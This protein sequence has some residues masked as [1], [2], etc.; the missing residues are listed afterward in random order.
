MS[1]KDFIP[2]LS[3]A[4]LDELLEYTPAFDRE[5]LANI[6]A[7]TFEKINQKEQPTMKKSSMRRSF[8]AL[9][10][11]CLIILLTSVTVFAAINLL[12]PSEI[13]YEMGDQRLSIA[14]DSDDAIHINKSY[15]TE[16]YRFTLL[17]IVS[18]HA[19]TDI[20]N[21]ARRYLDR[22]YLVVAIEREDGSPMVD[23]LDDAPRFYISPYIRG[24]KPWLVNLHTI[25][26]EGS[27]QH[28]MIIDGIRYV[29]VDME[30][31][32]AFADHGIYIGINTGWVF[33]GDA[34]DFTPDPWE[35]SA[36]PDFEGVSIVFELPICQSFADPVRAAEIL[37]ATP[38]LQAALQAQAEEL[39]E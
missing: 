28:E 13:A 9:A 34:F 23:F 22:S 24:Y 38:I 36:N 16:G 26:G 29:I 21:P 33:N 12:S 19:I 32:K 17:S 35:F 25:G 18:G 5:N 10:A 1:K 15:V 14:L 7:R 27:G 4:Q 20:F 31:I 8:S 11:A 39:Y 2:E 37:E 6:K 3:D 30:S